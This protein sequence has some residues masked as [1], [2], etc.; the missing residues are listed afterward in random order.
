LQWRDPKNFD[1]H[2]QQRTSLREI[3]V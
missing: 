1:A 2:G 3:A